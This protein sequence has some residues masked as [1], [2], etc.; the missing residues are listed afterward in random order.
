MGDRH[1]EPDMALRGQTAGN[2]GGTEGTLGARGG[3]EGTRWTAEVALSA[4]TPAVGVA[5]RGPWVPG[6]APRGQSLARVALRMRCIPLLALR[7][8]WV[9]GAVH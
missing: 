9:P 5:L 7:R 6:V 1:W 8:H 3:S 2:G 4:Q